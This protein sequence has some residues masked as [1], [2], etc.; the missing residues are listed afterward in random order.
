MQTQRTQILDAD[1]AG[2]RATSAAKPESCCVTRVDL[3]AS[4]E[5]G[6]GQHGGDADGAQLLRRRL[7]DDVGGVERHEELEGLFVG[8]AESE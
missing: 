3:M 4:K 1:G 2:D 6:G 5:S 7:Q 8:A